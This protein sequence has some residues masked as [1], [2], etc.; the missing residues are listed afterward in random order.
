MVRKGRWKCASNH[1]QYSSSPAAQREADKVQLKAHFLKAR[2]TQAEG[3]VY[4]SSAYQDEP[5]ALL[6][7]D[8]AISSR[9]D[10]SF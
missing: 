2:Q 8:Y 1:E 6:L 4:E 9:Q 5:A 10:A 7:Y 3:V